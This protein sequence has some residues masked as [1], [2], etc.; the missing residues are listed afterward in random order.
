MKDNNSSWFNLRDFD[1]MF[2]Y[3]TKIII[4]IVILTILIGVLLFSNVGNSKMSYVENT[5]LTNLGNTSLLRQEENKTSFMGIFMI[6]ILFVIFVLF[7][8]YYY[9]NV[10]KKKDEP[11]ENDDTD[12]KPYNPFSSPFNK[13][14]SFQ[15]YK[16]MN[17]IHN[18]K[19]N[20]TEEKFMNNIPIY[21]ETNEE[22]EFNGNVDKL[23]QKLCG[24]IMS[25]FTVK[26]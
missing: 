19:K 10:F 5:S 17:S 20:L 7:I 22:N 26:K 14:E 15:V 16:N 2:N 18:D 13:A 6:T 12:K 9:H 24:I 23:K 3:N 8:I 4:L 25:P 21:P 11:D 1:L